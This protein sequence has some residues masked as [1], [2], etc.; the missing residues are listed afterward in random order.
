MSH[1]G[2][3]MVSAWP[4]HGHSMPS[5]WPRHGL[6]MASQCYHHGTHYGHPIV[7]PW[8]HHGHTISCLPMA[9]L[10]MFTPWFGLVSTHGLTTMFSPCLATM[11]SPHGHATKSFHGDPMVSAWLTMVTP[12]PHHGHTMVSPWFDRGFSPVSWQDALWSPH[13][14]SMDPPQPHHVYLQ[15][16]S[17]CS[18]NGLAGIPMVSPP[19]FHNARPP[20]SHH[21]VMPPR[22][23]MFAPWLWLLST[24]GLTA[25]F[26]PCLTTMVSPHGHHHVSPWSPK[27]LASPWSHHVLTMGS[28]WFDLA[29]ATGIMTGRTMVT[30]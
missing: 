30:P 8:T 14:L 24:D 13:S 23:T 18:R 27:C 1:H 26:S 6:I 11:V 4:H 29:S 21:T 2:N 28:S 12:W 17:P 16:A 10:A 9:G 15:L 3:P 7:S 25:M 5:P 20:W 22:L 19:C